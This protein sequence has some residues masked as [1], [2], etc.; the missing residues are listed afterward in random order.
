MFLDLPL[1][2]EGDNLPFAPAQTGDSRSEGNNG[3]YLL[4]FLYSNDLVIYFRKPGVA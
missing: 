1:P 2:S 3:I 4:I